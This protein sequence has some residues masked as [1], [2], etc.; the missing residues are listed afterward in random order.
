MTTVTNLHNSENRAVR[1]YV[2]IA[3]NYALGVVAGIIPAC[4]FVRQACQRQINDLKDPPHGY[5]Y[6]VSFGERVC[7]FVELCPHIKGPLATKGLLLTLEPWQVFIL[8]TVFSWVDDE[9]NRRFRRVYIEVPRGNGKSAFAA[10]IGLYMLALDGEEGAEVYSAATTR[11]Q[12]RIV[13]RA[14]QQMVR[15]M[16]KYR[17]RFGVE[18]PAQAI[19]QQSTNSTFQALSADG[20]TL[21]GLNIHAAIIDEL[22]AHRTRDVYDVLES[23]FGKRLQSILWMITTAGAD[24]HG[25]C[26]EV[27]DYVLKVLNGDASD[28]AAESTFG[29]VYT[30]DEGDDYFAESSLRKAN[31]NWGVSVDPKAVMQTASK[32]KQVAT[33]R[34]GYLTK[35]LDIWVDANEA[36][37]DTECW[38]ACEDKTLN[39]LDFVADEMVAALDLASK[40]DIGARVN[41]YR[42]WNGN[43]QH[44]YFFPKFWLPMQAIEEDRHPFYRGWEMGGHITGT[45][46]ETIDFETIKDDIVENTI[47]SNIQAICADPW[48]ATYLLQKLE[49]EGLPA[50]EYRMTVQNMSEATKTF[51]AIMREGRAHHPGNPVFN[52][53][54]GNVVGHYDAKE[55]VFPNKERR[56]NKID[57]AIAAIMGLG[58]FVKGGEAEGPSIYEERGVLFL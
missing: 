32:A 48:Q 44:F 33:A 50:E 38:R 1:D 9:G 6:D 49:A 24:K 54:V 12:A 23:G 11:D 18:V 56:A 2:Q 25:I 53:M 15:K 7:S 29:I 16:P 58:W 19:V 36:L 55:N 5:V 46:G 47:G 31:P 4:K 28:D 22:H 8:M 26:Y 52:W 27:R 34:P 20:H 41:V 17:R 10:P 21:D 40:I 45:P 14:A 3:E 57:G 51:D 42:R 30:I 35:H 13:F 37:F 43:E 39:E